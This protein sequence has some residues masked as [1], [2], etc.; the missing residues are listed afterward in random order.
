MEK[1][2]TMF[3]AALFLMI[4]TALAQTKVNGTVTSQEDG[5]PVIGA[6]V[7]VVGTQ[8]GTVTD[9]NGHFSLTMPEGKKT[10]RITYVGMEPIEVSAR[11]NMRIML[12]NDQAALDEVIVVAYGTAKKSAFT[13]SAGVVKADDIAKVQ[14]VNASEALR[15]KVTGVQMVQGSGQPGTAPTIRIRGI[16][17]TSTVSGA[18]DPLF[19]V[20]GSPFDGDI[21]TISPSDIESMTVLKEASAAALYGARGANGVIIITTKSGQKGKDATITFDAKWG[22]NSRA[23]PDYEFISSPAAYY[24]MWYKGLYNYGV[25]TY[26]Y[27]AAQANAYAN[28]AMFTGTT[29]LGYNVYTVPEGQNL[30]GMN[31]KLNPNATLGRKITNN[32]QD[33]WIQPDNFIDETYSNSLRQEYTLTASGSTERSTFYASGNY[34]KMK[35]ITPMSNYERFAARLKADY[36]LKPWLKLGVNVNYAH[37]N[38]D[39]V[40]SESSGS[41]ANMFAMTTVAPIYPLYVRDGNG[42][43]IIHPDSKQPTFDYGDG[44]YTGI[45]RPSMNGANPLSD[46]YSN[47]R[48]TIG[49]TFN[50]VGTADIRFL[51]DFKFT[52]INSTYV[53]EYRGMSTYNP[54]FGSNAPN[55]GHSYVSHGRTWTYN[56]QQLLDW[57][58]LFDKH[59]VDV[60]IGHEYYRRYVSGLEADKTNIFLNENGELDGAV[61]AG[62]SQSSSTS[63]YNTEGW[64]SRIQYNYDE[65][66][67]ASASYRRD[68]TSTFHPDH[69]WGNFWSFGA[70]WLINKE[71]FFKA[72]WVDE[73]K[74]KASYGEQGN[75][76]IGQYNYITT[77]ALR[78]SGGQIGVAPNRMGNEKISWEKV[79]EFNV[80]VD[81][82]LWKGRLSGGIEY[83]YRK[84]TD[85][86]AWFSLPASFGFTGY[87]DNIGDVRNK[88]VEIQLRGDFIRTKDLTW[89]AYLNATSNS[90]KILKIADANKRMVV[91]GVSGYQSS[92]YFYGEGIP[93]YTNYMYRYAGVDPETGE[94]L[95]YKNVYKKDA[96]GKNILDEA[97]NPIVD[98]LDTTNKTGDAD[99]YLCGN[100]HPDWFGGFGTSLSWNGFDVS[101]D[102]T[103]QLGGKVYDSNYASAMAFSRGSQMH[104]DLLNAWSSTNTNSDI[105]RI[106]YNDHYTAA[107]SDRFL[108]SAS[109]LCLQNVTIGYTLPTSLVRKL[110]FINKI[111]VY[112][113]GDNLWLWS[114]RQ[115]LDPRQSI[116]GSV[117]NE[118]YSPIRTIS[119]GITVTF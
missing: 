41:T 114:K 100:P 98:H 88:G 81:F 62:T 76:R 33:Y 78:N 7:L 66:Y 10:L 84:T 2:L 57:H 94:A 6:S 21:N 79:G 101:V 14:T 23:I 46:A 19:V 20:D 97:G 87:Y 116:S 82:S 99:Q 71:N 16:T 69:R 18:N 54:W 73:L 63:T 53:D 32:G 106:Q 74:L 110:G 112:A 39:N 9:V 29:G 5:Q 22:S 37:Y 47:K 56:F 13:G 50:I 119:G 45:T 60:M 103:Y 26:G 44:Q 77:Y 15:G 51:K 80:G 24:E 96:D 36:Q 92:G 68:A 85:M 28:E 40:S 83:Y 89:S 111:R 115:G 17:T 118:T 86:L 8:V 11:P 105:P 43:I 3:F 64:F 59:D 109:Y 52:S 117:S 48:N 31:G 95:Y 90:M 12:T 104:V 49:N 38:Q 70:A 58:H 25:D 35:G 113:V 4:G 27:T 108:I 61:V 72:D 30:I 65:K 102:F 67:F 93:I 34:L 42:N 91:D 75:D 107:T 55:K 1:R